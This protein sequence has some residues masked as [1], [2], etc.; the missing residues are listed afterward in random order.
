[1]RADLFRML[2][3]P[4]L[5]SLVFL[6]GCI[7]PGDPLARRGDEIV[8]CGQLFHIGTPVVLWLDPNGYDAY[9]CRRH[10]E[11][12]ETMPSAPVAPGN[13]S[14]FSNRYS[15]PDD[16][17]ERV[18]RQGW[19]LENLREQVDLFVFHYDACGT[20]AQ[21]FKVLQDI[22][23]LSVQFMCDLDGTIYQT[24]DLKERAWHAGDVNCRCVGIEIANI[25]AY[26]DMDTL[27]KWYALDVGGWPYCIFPADFDMAR[28]RT[29]GFVGR[30][31]RKGVFKG[32]VN[33]R[34]LMQYD[35]TSQQYAAL[36]KLAAAMHR[37]FPRI[38]LDVPRN[39]DGSV[40][41]DLL[42]PD[43]LKAYSGFLGH[44]HTIKVK[45]DPGPAFDWDRVINGARREL[46]IW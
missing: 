44:Q 42:P 35:Y 31:A 22:R 45:V 26:P 1:M 9:R 25:G 24:L 18:A 12:A 15:M 32:H 19:T 28:F 4:A 11:P 13:P 29:P 2:V 33:G 7:R 27:D 10:F 40:N 6:T 17:K 38:R 23:G 5:F 41:P 3:L 14:R 20:S 37:L 39:P 34:D 16:L 21:C 30:P 8:V 36:I 43:E 46:G